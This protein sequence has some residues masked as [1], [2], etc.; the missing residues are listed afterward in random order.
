MSLDSHVKARREIEEINRF[1]NKHGGTLPFT[2]Q[3]ILL[4]RKAVA[5]WVIKI[6][7]G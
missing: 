6:A 3:K 5:E 4:E 2:I 7:K 1:M